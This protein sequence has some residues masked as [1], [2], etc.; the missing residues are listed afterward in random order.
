MQTLELL[1]H[2]NVQHTDL[3]LKLFQNYLN[4]QSEREYYLASAKEASTLLN[5]LSLETK[6]PYVKIAFQHKMMQLQ[7][8]GQQ[9]QHGQHSLH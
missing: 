5:Y 1:K 3:N 2:E 4:K 6:T 7:Q 9:G 8:Q